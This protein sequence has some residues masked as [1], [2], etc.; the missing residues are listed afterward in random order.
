[1][2]SKELP[3]SSLG[4]A[5]QFPRNCR[6]VPKELLASSRGTAGRL[7]FP[8]N[9][10]AGQFPRNC[11]PVPKELLAALNFQGA[12]SPVPNL[13]RNC[14]PDWQ[15]PRNCWQFPRNCWQFPRNCWPP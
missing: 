3:A 10:G 1:M 5:G 13:A 4:T 15:F 14:W 2:Q 6:P 8:R 12:A 11:R 9:L 7:K